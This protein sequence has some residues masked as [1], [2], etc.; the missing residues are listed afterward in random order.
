[1]LDHPQSRHFDPSHDLAFQTPIRLPAQRKGRA[2]PD[3][4]VNDILTGKAQLS[5][6]SSP[7]CNT[8]HPEALHEIGLT[9]EEV[10]EVLR[11][12]ASLSLRLEPGYG[13]ESPSPCQRISQSKSSACRYRYQSTLPAQLSNRDHSIDS[14][15]DESLLS[16]MQPTLNADHEIIKYQPC[17]ANLTPHHHR[18][19]T[20]PITVARSP[21]ASRNRSTSTDSSASDS[22]SNSSSKPSTAT[23]APDRLEPCE[24]FG[25]LASMASTISILQQRIAELEN[26]FRDMEEELEYWK[27]EAERVKF[28]DAGWY[29]F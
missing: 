8:G 16:T 26:K 29:I 12:R 15:A 17:N 18:A 25:P 1:M 22:R 20:F 2:S 5:T 28:E 4:L 14:I 11:R 21:T 27:G 23:S 7:R 19:S 9:L 10:D 24:S 3:V 6:F 13:S